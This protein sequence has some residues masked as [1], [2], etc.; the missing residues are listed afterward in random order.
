MRRKC[1]AVILILSL[2]LPMLLPASIFAESVYKEVAVYELDEMKK[3]LLESEEAK[4]IEKA[5][6]TFPVNAAMAGVGTEMIFHLF[7]QGNAEAAQTV[8]LGTFDITG[9][10]ENHYEIV[11]DGKPVDG[12]AN[13]LLDG[14]GT[15]YNVF[16]GENVLEDQQSENLDEAE[17]NRQMEEIKGMASS[18]FDVAFAPGETEKEIRI[19]AYV[20]AKAMGNREFQLAILECPEM[21]MGE[22]R[23]VAVT[24]CDERTPESAEISFDPDSAKV[25]DGYL[26]V[27][28]ERKGNT[29][30]N[31]MYSV[32]AEDGTAKNGEDFKL[33]PSQ[34]TFT[35]GVTKQRVHIPLMSSG[36]EETKEFTLRVNDQA[37]TI[38]Y[39][40]PLRGATFKA[41]RDRVDIDMANFVRGGQTVSSSLCPTSFKQAN[42]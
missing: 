5:T 35:P 26:S 32:T 13:P 9:E 30:G 37:E 24:L 2:V 23:A 33:N 1:T 28:V 19:R 20:P 22:N 16:L 36:S 31:T 11:V 8:T 29:V 38:T 39:T 4:K 40:Q 12:K 3:E 27:E 41:A 25:E 34:L 17:I 6:A 42:Y 7:R 14:A 21:D 18:T 10:Y 15:V